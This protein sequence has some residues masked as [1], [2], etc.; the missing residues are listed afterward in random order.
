MT[1]SSCRKKRKKRSF[2]FSTMKELKKAREYKSKKKLTIEEGCSVQK[3]LE[4][5]QKHQDIGKA[6]DSEDGNQTP[7][8]NTMVVGSD[9]DEEAFQEVEDDSPRAEGTVVCKLITSQ[10]F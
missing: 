8:V 6:S 5:P 4:Y 10:S 3:I 2:R 9:E 7:Q 1:P